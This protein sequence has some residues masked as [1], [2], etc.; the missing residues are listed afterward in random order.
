MITNAANLISN[1][2]IKD[3]EQ[4]VIMSI[5]SHSYL[6]D[7]INKIYE[8]NKLKYYEL[9]RNSTYFN[10]KSFMFCT[11]QNYVN[12]QRFSGIFLYEKSISKNSITMNLIKKGYK[13]IYNFIKNNQCVNFY[14]LRNDYLKFISENVY[15][16]TVKS[17]HV[18]AIALY[19]CEEFK[20]NI[21]YEEWDID[22]MIK[23][24]FD[25][26]QYVTS[27]KDLNFNESKIIE[28][29]E[30]YADIGITKKSFKLTLNEFT[31]TMS[32]Q[33]MEKMSKVAVTNK[34]SDEQLNNITINSPFFKSLNFISRILFFCDIDVLDLQSITI[35]DYE[36]VKQIVQLCLEGINYNELPE[37]DM[38]QLFAVSL[39]LYSLAQE[40]NITKN[41][42][43]GNAHEKTIYETMRLKEE[44]G[45]KLV[46]LTKR[47]ESAEIEVNKLKRLNR[48]SMDEIYALK[49]QLKDREKEIFQLG[50]KYDKL[51][52][53]SDELTQIIELY[54]LQ[55]N[56]IEKIGME[57]MIKFISSRKCVVV[58]GHVNW[59]EKLQNM[60][61]NSRFISADELNKDMCFLTNLDA[62]LFNESINSHAMFNK[63]KALSEGRNIPLILIGKFNNIELTIQNI[64]NELK[65]YYN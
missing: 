6:H 61:S 35:L 22:N 41:E 17:S 13:F 30:K 42:Y 46:S 19:L 5:G 23:P 29:L 1:L 20:V 50:I 14:K 65:S 21:Q 63:I 16:Q 10:N 34:I 56:E 12:I 37:L 36:K 11:T 43:L 24:S 27:Y 47:E 38:D 8:N 15:E 7:E 2:G 62:I 57:D 40:Y 31:S 49:K 64:Y 45:N 26:Y 58:G 18:F 55:Y 44:Y 33:R 59:Q 28:Y 39:I 3:F 48:E 52:K 51:E 53:Q 4:F 25:T 32:R 54:R 60:L 9:Y